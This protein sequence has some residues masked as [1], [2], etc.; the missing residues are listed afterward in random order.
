MG[1]E[2]KAEADSSGL[3]RNDKR[4]CGK[5]LLSHSSRWGCDEWGTE[6]FGGGGRKANTEILRCPQNDLGRGLAAI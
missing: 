4:G 2:G 1:A 6:G 3:L 5:S